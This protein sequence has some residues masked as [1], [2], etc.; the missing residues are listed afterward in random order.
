MA[1]YPRSQMA[2]EAYGD[3][4]QDG[5]SEDRFAVRFLQGA[6]RAV[7]GKIGRRRNPQTV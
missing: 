2:I 4:A 1:L 3:S 5:S 6:L 7:T